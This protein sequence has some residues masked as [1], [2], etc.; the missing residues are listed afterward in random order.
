MADELNITEEARDD[1]ALAVM[2]R[3]R[4]AKEWRDTYVVHQGMSASALMN[5]SE[6]QYRREYTPGDAEQMMASFG[7][8]PTRY[9][10]IV[11][12]KTNATFNWKLDLV[13]TSLDTL[14]TVTPTPE[15]DLDDASRRRI[16]DGVRREL[17]QRMADSG[18]A[19][20]SLLLT[21][22]GD[23]DYRIEDY[24]AEQV[25]VLKQVEQARIV[26]TATGAAAKMQTRMR[27]VLVEGGFRQEYGHF[28]F[29]QILH[30]R[31][32]IRF[33]HFRN[34]A[35]LSHNSKRSGVH[36]TTA[37]RPVFSH[38]RVQDFYPIDDASDLR[39]NTGNTERTEITKHELIRLTKVPGYQEDQILDILEEYAFKNRNWLGPED[40]S[41]RAAGWW[42]PDGTTPILIHE[43]YFS[44]DELREYGIDGLEPHDMYSAR[45]EVCAWRTIR[46]QLL[47]YPKGPGRTYSQ[48]PF[49][50]TG[51][52]LY[53]AIGMGA[54]LWDEEQRVNRLM[55]LFEHNIDWATRPPVMANKAAFST[56][57]DADLITP[58]GQYDVEE[59]FGTTGSM[60]DAMRTMN[61]IS[62]QYHL[63]MTQVGAL[64]RQADESCGVPAFAYSSQDFGRSSLGEYTQRMSNALRTIKG[65]A[66]N[67]DFFFVEPAFTELFRHEML[68]DPDL[69][70]GQ[71]INVVIRGM[72]G[73]LREDIAAQRQ[74]AILPMIINGANQGLVPEEAVRYAVR[75]MLEQAGFPV[76]ALGMS[77]PVIDNALAVAANQP[78]PGGLP[79]G[80]Q[81]PQLD[82]R[83]GPIPNANFASPDGLSNLSQSGPF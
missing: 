23:V 34:I 14:F 20:P 38:V 37:V 39:E 27:D 11:Q 75:Q 1:I 32:V 54:M 83:S 82:G 70:V 72:T 57:S 77:D 24:L 59:R 79:A 55:H 7:F 41:T 8:C 6:Y 30:G 13:L 62:A 9:M 47:E 19:D 42:G 16:R 44:G 50:P 76:D 43:G 73:L 60:P 25:Q 40:D 56:P 3:F 2:Q 74:Q 71:D 18:I 80:Q 49:V 69:T 68:A 53:D 5:R 67:E 15:P 58:G 17:M 61:P 64:L 81:V 21:N 65:L 66:Q 78:L 35:T 46:C 12:Q 31:G 33:P 45:V 52:N 51:K 36:M 22:R 29:D 63:I 4:R 48:V 28:T 10:G 26:S